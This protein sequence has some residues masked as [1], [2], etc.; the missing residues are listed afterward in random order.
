[1]VLQRADFSSLSN[2]LQSLREAVQHNCD[3]A[4]ARHALDYSLCTYLLKMREYYRWSD[5]LGYDVDLSATDVAGWVDAQEQ[6]WAKLEGAPFA[7]ITVEQTD[8]DVFDNEGINKVLNAQGV[9]YS[10]GLGKF[11]RPLF[12][13]GE[14]L[15]TEELEGYRILICEQEY[16]RGL[17]AP[18]AMANG[19]LIVIRRDALRRVLWEIIEDW[20]WKKPE[21]ALARAIR[22]YD[23]DTDVNNALERMTDHEM[24]ALILHEIGEVV[25]GEILGSRWHTMMTTLSRPTAEIMVRGVRDHLADCLSALPAL[26]NSADTPSLHF[27]F[28]NLTAMRKEL[29]PTLVDAYQHWVESQDLSRL[30]RVVREGKDHWLAVAGRILEFHQRYGNG[31]QQP[32]E[33]FVTKSQ[34]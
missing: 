28:A 31:C 11:L 34:F 16:A 8:F 21:D 15:A 9:A 26:L 10:A 13:L 6:R 30:K 25:A 29:F 7:P 5:E 19:R 17:T 1:M 23:F 18:P 12:F 32:I 27:Y 22:F 24:E 33:S 20:R 14:L 3:I 4:D 2:T